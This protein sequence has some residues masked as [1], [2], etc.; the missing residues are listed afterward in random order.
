M[1]RSKGLLCA[2]RFLSTSIAILL[3]V[4]ATFALGQT[5]KDIYEFGGG[6]DGQGPNGA[7]V[8][9]SSGSLYGVTE[10]GGLY[11][12]GT[13][14]KLSPPSEPGAP[15]T[16]KV[17]YNFTGSADGSDPFAAL[18]LDNTGSL[19]GVNGS[20]GDLTQCSQGCGTIFQ[21][22]PPAE[23][24]DPWTETTIYTFQNELGKTGLALDAAG[25]LYAAA[26]SYT[27]NA[28]YIFKLSPPQA[29]RGA[30]TKTFL[31][32]VAFNIEPELV[33]DNAGAL[34]G[35][36]WSS[37]FKLS[38]PASP[39]GDW[40]LHYIYHFPY[41]ADPY[42]GPV[43]G[44]STGHLFGTASQGGPTG[45]GSTCGAVYELAGSGNVWHEENI[46][47]FTGGKDGFQPMAAVTFDSTGALYTTSSVGSEFG[48]GSVIRLTRMQT[49]AWSETT[50][51]KV[52]GGDYSGPVSAVVVHDGNLF[53]T[54]Q[55]GGSGY[56]AVFQVKP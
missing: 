40:T 18:V 35:A 3:L 6:T 39:A 55:K 51:W 14:Y 24:G 48:P 30:W 33:F 8:F 50:L 12:S 19:Y 27:T 34:Y 44:K 43:F 38:P 5:G 47:D 36:V 45:C 31:S 42:A 32:N 26:S 53:G 28:T 25:A 37:I 21:L 29:V 41:N 22:T 23:Q 49:G 15:W 54:T 17:I 46:Y 52:I 20:G 11:S 4:S 13:V 9:D 10:E 1:K 7:V 16:K 56:G 2:P